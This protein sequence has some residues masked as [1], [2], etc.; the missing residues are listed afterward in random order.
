M[1]LSLRKSLFYSSFPSAHGNSLRSIIMHLE[2]LS[3]KEVVLL[4]LFTGIPLL[5]EYVNGAFIRRGTPLPKSQPGVYALSQGKDQPIWQKLTM[6]K[7]F[8][9]RFLCVW[10]WLSFQLYG[11]WSIHDS[12]I[13]VYSHWDTGVARYKDTLATLHP[14]YST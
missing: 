8:R 7:I 9:S 3:P 2:N 4:E 6:D 13:Y 1:W 5:Y 11:H 12:I 14:G 10:K